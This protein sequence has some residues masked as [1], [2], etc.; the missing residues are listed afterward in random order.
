MPV[1]QAIL[2]DLVAISTENHLPQKSANLASYVLSPMEVVADVSIPVL[3]Y[4][5]RTRP[6][7]T[8]IE[9]RF[10]QVQQHVLIHK[11]IP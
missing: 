9:D 7:G 3:K 10:F 2:F 4:K 6:E 5:K 11:N 8:M 1:T